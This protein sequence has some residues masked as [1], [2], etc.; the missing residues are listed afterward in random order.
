M[1]CGSGGTGVVMSEWWYGSGDVGVVVRERW[2]WSGGARVAVW[3][4]GVGVREC[5][6][7]I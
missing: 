5:G 2:Y 7:N 1:W 3:C 6:A 4:A